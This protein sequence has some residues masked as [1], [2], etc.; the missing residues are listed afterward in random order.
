GEIHLHGV[1]YR[2]RSLH[3][4]QSKLGIVLQEPHLF[5]GSV[6]ENLR[7]GRLD[8]TD[9]EITAAA[10]LAGAHD[11]IAALEKGYE[12][13]VGEGGNRLSTGQ[14]QL[15]SFARAVLKQPQIL[16]MDEATSSVDTETEQRIQAGLARVLEGRTSFVIAHRLSTIRA[17]DRILVIEHG[18]I[19]EE[20]SHDGLMARQ[21]RYHDL[22][23]QQSLRESLHG[24]WAKESLP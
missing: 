7:Y 14:K 20:G 9:E 22:Y 21:G 23:T 16:V 2:Q 17:A 18:R 6:K 1:D 19:A 11:F 13:D 4:L 10:R 24:D 8:A 3:W 5:R 12:T 15:L